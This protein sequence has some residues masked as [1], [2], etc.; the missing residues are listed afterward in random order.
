METPNYRCGESM[1]KRIR[2]FMLFWIG[3]PNT[4]LFTNRVNG[5]YPVQF[6]RR[7][8]IKKIRH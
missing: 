1:S 7:D 6:Y 5:V 2:D 4:T 8:N 3:C